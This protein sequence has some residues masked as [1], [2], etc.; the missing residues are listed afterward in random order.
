MSETPEVNV[1]VNPDNGDDKNPTAEAD[2]QGAE[3][4]NEPRPDGKTDSSE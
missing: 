4:A 3:H 1:N 2:V